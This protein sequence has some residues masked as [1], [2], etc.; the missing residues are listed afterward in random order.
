MNTAVKHAELIHIHP[1][2]RRVLKDTIKFYQSMV[3]FIGDVVCENREAVFA[4]TGKKRL[5]AVEHLIHRTK[6]N[7]EPK[8]PEFERLYYKTPSGIRRS[9]INFVLGEVSSFDTRFEQYET[10]KYHAMS[11]GLKFRKR[12]P[13]LN[14]KA[15]AFPVLYDTVFKRDGRSVKI[16]VRIRNTWD[17]INISIS[18]RDLKSLTGKIKSPTLQF[19]Y[20]KF[21]L[22]FSVKYKAAVFPDTELED[23]R[24]LS[25]DLGINNGAVC[26][27]I[28][29]AGTIHKRLF[30]PFKK[31]TDRIDRKIAEIRTVQETSGRGQSLS[32]VY[33]K[34]DGFKLNYVRQLAHWIVKQARDNEVYGIVLEHLGKMKSSWGKKDRIHHWCKCR[35]RDMIKGM[36]I[37]YGIRVFIVNPKNTSA[38][39]FDG[40]GPVVR[41]KTNYSLCAFTTGKQYNCDL[42]ASYNIG[43]RYFIR[44][45]LKTPIAGQLMAKVP[46]LSKRTDCT[47]STLRSLAKEKAALV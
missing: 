26:S 38:L 30:S 40:S 13:T 44:E 41:D 33:T 18:N 23:R 24:V 12:P 45:Y 31:D 6:D 8:Y 14:L 25:V 34:L 43:A 10:E 46:E 39:A 3:E 27:V 32:A 4:E 36:A 17:W 16:K 37:R 2:L 1:G 22:V 5:N 15:N 20:N 21:Y 35:I 11:N 42:S 9:A 19:K 28:D 47:L 29:S 7:P